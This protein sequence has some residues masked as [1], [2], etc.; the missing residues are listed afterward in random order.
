MVD[1]QHGERPLQ[2]EADP[3]DAGRREAI[4]KLRRQLAMLHEQAQTSSTPADQVHL[5]AQVA[6]L[7]DMIRELKD[8]PV[9]GFGM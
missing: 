4:A 8:K 9:A 7:M 5:V 3:E 2:T 6:A 1:F